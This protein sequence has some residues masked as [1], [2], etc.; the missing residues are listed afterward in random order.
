MSDP[1][2]PPPDLIETLIGLLNQLT[3]RQK[4]GVAH[5]GPGWYVRRTCDCHKREIVSVRF[6]TEDEAVRCRQALDDDCRRSL[7][8]VE[9]LA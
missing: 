4:D 3:L 9:M 7:S 5:T 2:R 6:G 1:Q 8:A